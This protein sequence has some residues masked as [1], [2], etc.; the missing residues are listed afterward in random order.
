MMGACTCNCKHSDGL[1]ENALCYACQANFH[2]CNWIRFCS[3]PQKKKKKITQLLSIVDLD[4]AAY[5]G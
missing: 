1:T 5:P 2:I 3:Q 4:G